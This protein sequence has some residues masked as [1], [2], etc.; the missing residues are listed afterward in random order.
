MEN[1]RKVWQ[2][3]VSRSSDTVPQYPGMGR[4]R[5]GVVEVDGVQ[6]PVEV[7]GGGVEHKRSELR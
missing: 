3:P 7:E 4:A 1:D 5:Y 6:R 2:G